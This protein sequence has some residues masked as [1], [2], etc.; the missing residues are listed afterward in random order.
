MIKIKVSKLD[1]TK[2]KKDLEIALHNVLVQSIIDH[3]LFKEV[4]LMQL[5]KKQIRSVKASDY[6]NIR[7]EIICSDE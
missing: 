2:L 6:K 7:I 3:P 4:S 1:N 5:C